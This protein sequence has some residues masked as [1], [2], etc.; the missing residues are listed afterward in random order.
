MTDTASNA[1]IGSILTGMIRDSHAVTNN[2]IDGHLDAAIDWAKRF[3]KLYQRLEYAI[4]SG[5][6][7]QASR[8][9]DQFA[10]DYDDVPRAVKH[11]ESMKMG[12]QS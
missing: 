2:L 11:Y 7:L 9:L 4:E 10:Y 3:E 1:L 12:G 6:I 8:I 5:N